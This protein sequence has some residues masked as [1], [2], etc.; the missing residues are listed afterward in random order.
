LNKLLEAVDADHAE[1]FEKAL[2]KQDE[3]H[4]AKLQQVVEQYEKALVED[5]KALREELE[6]DLSNFL[7]LYIEKLVPAEDIKKAV[8]N[9]QATRIVESIKQ[10]VAIDDKF[11]NENIKEALRDG[12]EKIDQ[13]H[14][15]LNQTLKENIDLK[16]VIQRSQAKELLDEKTADL[17]PTKKKF[18][19]KFLEGKTPEYI[20]EN[21][22]YVVEMFERDE[23]EGAQEQVI[24]ESAS[25][26]KRR[27]RKTDDV[28]T[29]K[30]ILEEKAASNAPMNEYLKG[31]E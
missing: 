5:S 25:P 17:H 10:L 30:T 15:K 13:L 24:T 12:K 22:S 26:K 1:K 21:Y 2:A 8:E 31:L 9:T 27:E 18:I 3:D 28:D 6:E 20:K 7:D 29:P 4:T 19:Y 16:R 14:T 11:I 23:E